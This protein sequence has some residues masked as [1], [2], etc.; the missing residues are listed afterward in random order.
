MAVNDK[1][2]IERMAAR[3]KADADEVRKLEKAIIEDYKSGID[4]ESIARKNDSTYKRV[5]MT[6]NTYCRD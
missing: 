2:A 4:Y 3:L 6:I 1:E 5:T